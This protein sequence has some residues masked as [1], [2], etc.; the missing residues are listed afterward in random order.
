VRSSSRLSH[1]RPVDSVHLPA[2][3]GTAILALK[4]TENKAV[5]SFAEEMIR[6]HLAVNNKVLALLHKWKVT[7]EESDTSRMIYQN[8]T[9]K[10]ERAAKTLGF[11]AALSKGKVG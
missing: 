8:A 1:S 9:V 10:Q 5:E 6:D 4:K 11:Y 3:I 2:D 7:P